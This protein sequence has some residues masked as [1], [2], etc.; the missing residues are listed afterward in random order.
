MACVREVLI[1]STHILYR[2]G[3]GQSDLYCVYS[4][5][6][7]LVYISPLNPVPEMHYSPLPAAQTPESSNGRWHAQLLQSDLALMAAAAELPIVPLAISGPISCD[8]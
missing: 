5:R 2:A 7:H 8:H 1:L 3:I 4:Q 6:Y